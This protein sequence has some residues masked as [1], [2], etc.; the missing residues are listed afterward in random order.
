MLQELTPRETDVIRLVAKGLANKQIAQELDLSPSTV[1]GYMETIML[2]L[3]APNRT[4]AAA[5]WLASR[6][7]PPGGPRR[8]AEL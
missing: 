6:E 3:G 7:S 8:T 4:A 5:R 1:K 2:K